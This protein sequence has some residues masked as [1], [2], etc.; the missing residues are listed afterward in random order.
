MIYYNTRGLNSIKKQER[1]TN[2]LAVLKPDVLALSETRLTKNLC[3]GGY[4]TSKSAKNS[5]GGCL[6]ATNNQRMK[7]IKTLGTYLN[8]SSVPFQDIPLHIFTCYLEPV[9]H[10]NITERSN[11]ILALIENL[12][13]RDRQARII[14][15]GDFNMQLPLFK[16]RLNQLGVSQLLDDSKPT[17]SQGNQ[18]DQAFSNI[19]GISAETGGCDSDITDHLPIWLIVPLKKQPG[20]VT[21]SEGL[22]RVTEKSLRAASLTQ[23]FANRLL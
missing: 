23:E 16:K 20:E 15:I 19:P 10:G 21:L 13:K 2:D 7:R 1:L 22:T 11:K 6:L 4:R 9:N 18:L 12:L 5:K 3:F 8:W 17:H 14:V